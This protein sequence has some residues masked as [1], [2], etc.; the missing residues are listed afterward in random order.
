M[1]FNQ[2]SGIGKKQLQIL[3]GRKYAIR[4]GLKFD[5]GLPGGKY[6]TALALA[7]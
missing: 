2:Q 3:G 4:K 7:G 1:A 6:A 5:F